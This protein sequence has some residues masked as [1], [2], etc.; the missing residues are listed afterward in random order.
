[1]DIWEELFKIKKK[2][3]KRK[4]KDNKKLKIKL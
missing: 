3:L 4:R 2:N 1:M